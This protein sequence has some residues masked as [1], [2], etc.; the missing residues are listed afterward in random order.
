MTVVVHDCIPLEPPPISV[1]DAIR[2]AAQTDP[3]AGH[4]SISL[5]RHYQA[6]DACLALR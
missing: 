1:V 3:N 4:W 5:E 2:V 6:I